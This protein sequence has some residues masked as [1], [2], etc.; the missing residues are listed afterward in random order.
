M[1]EKIEEWVHQVN[2]SHRDVRRSCSVLADHFNGFY[3]PNFLKT[4]FFVVTDEIPKPDFSGLR[5]AGLGDFIDMEVGGITY[6]D[7]YYV[8]KKAA[9]EFRLHFHEL[10]HVLQW[11]ELAPQGFIERYI[12]EIQDFGYDNAPL[13]KM[14]YALDGHYQSKGRPFSVEQFV[15]ENL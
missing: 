10:V 13:E 6:N 14:A 8:K 5:E 3:S 15:R 7:T 11:R 9:N 12:R 4:A 1:I 2:S